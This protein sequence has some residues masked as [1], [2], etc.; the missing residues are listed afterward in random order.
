[1]AALF[2]TN[3]GLFCFKLK[4]YLFLFHFS[5]L[6][7]TQAM[8]YGVNGQ[9]GVGYRKNKNLTEVVVAQFKDRLSNIPRDTEKIHE[10]SSEWTVL[11]RNF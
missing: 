11:R 2:H 6:S 5:A 7:V 9:R 4:V 1:M 8:V 3:R 10:K